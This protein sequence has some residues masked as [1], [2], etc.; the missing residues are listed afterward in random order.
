MLGAYIE[1]VRKISPLV[2]NIT[3]YVTANDVANIILACG[4]NPIMSDEPKDVINITSICNG[5]NINIGTLN[6]RSIKA[7]FISGKQAN[8][9]GNI[10]VLD[11]V[12]AG[13]STFRTETAIKLLQEINFDCIKGNMSEIKA[14]ALGHSETKGVSANDLDTVTNETL[15]ESIKFIKSFAKRKKCIVAITGNIDLV[16]NGEICYVIKNG[17]PNMSK[18]TG[19]GC[20]LSG[21]ITAFIAA[22]QNNKLKATV[23]A[24]CT[25]GVAGEIGHS[26]MKQYDGNCTYRNSIIDAVCNMNGEILD[27]GAKYE[28]R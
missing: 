9:L 19:T 16:S 28:I 24:I 8:K 10:V 7:M 11:P 25:M 5:L 13:S 4:G 26:H 27:K 6:E 1:K 15:D 21:L 14:L 12:G 17:H 20:Q 3:N 2:H 18:V 23:A 22:N